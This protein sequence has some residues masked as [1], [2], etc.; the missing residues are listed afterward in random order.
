[1]D[2]IYISLCQ[3]G[4]LQP[5]WPLRPIWPDLFSDKIL[6]LN[7]LRLK[8]TQFDPFI[9][10]MVKIATSNVNWRGCYLLS[11]RVASFRFFIRAL[12]A[13]PLLL[14]VLASQFPHGFFCFSFLKIQLQ[15]SFFLPLQLFS[16]VLVFL[17][18]PRVLGLT[19]FKIEELSS[20]SNNNIYYRTSYYY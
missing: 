16:V 12:W 13:W 5:V 10:Y 7:R 18:P 9:I 8:T 4:N 15:A 14:H 3:A 11:P 6:Y 1:M 20:V 2:W 19:I 17:F